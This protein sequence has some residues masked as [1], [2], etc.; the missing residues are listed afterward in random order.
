MKGNKEKRLLD[1]GFA[2]IER[3]APFGESVELDFKE[4]AKGIFSL[5]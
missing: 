1:Y 5:L 2:E 3:V 4:D